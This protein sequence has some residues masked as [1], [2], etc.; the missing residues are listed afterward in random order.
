MEKAFANSKDIEFQA[1]TW[2]IKE[3]EDSNEFTMQCFGVTPNGKSIL[4]NIIEYQP[5]FYVKVPKKTGPWDES[6]LAAFKQDLKWWEANEIAF[7]QFKL[8]GRIPVTGWTD[9]E[10]AQFVK[11]VVNNNSAFK[12]LAGYLKTP[13]TKTG[14]EKIYRTL[15]SSGPLS[16]ELFES[17]VDPHI[18]FM[19]E[20]EITPAGMITLK[21]C[22]YEVI[23]KEEQESLS[24]IEVNVH[25]KNV[26]PG[27]VKSATPFK[28]ASFDI[29]CTS[30]NGDFPI[31][32]KP[33]DKI[34]QIFTTFYKY[35]DKEPYYTH[36][37]ILD[38][39]DPI[40]GVDMECF[41]KEKDVI[42]AWRNAIRRVDPD[43]ILGYNIL[44]F[45][46]AYL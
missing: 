4:C 30:E 34:I 36:A 39:C 40:E 3:D 20:K 42:M 37:A 32:Q 14:R 43:V 11:I 19:H 35:G 1:I 2:D 23:D 13:K 28:F 44:G 17:N 26:Y 12:K 5:Y 22:E 9:K 41:E 38:T 15:H 18:R 29:E 46:L 27:E 33:G 24:N 16:F 31:A 45:D 21:K 10:N 7:D 6:H 25:W 8:V